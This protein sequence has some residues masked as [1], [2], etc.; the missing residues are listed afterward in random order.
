MK[1]S[2]IEICLTV[3]GKITDS[4]DFQEQ[5]VKTYQSPTVRISDA[6]G[7]VFCVEMM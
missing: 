5:L 7:I 3:I 4:A 2:N 1:K 6:W